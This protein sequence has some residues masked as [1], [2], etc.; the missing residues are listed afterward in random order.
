M[1][2]PLMK[3][4]KYAAIQL[5]HSTICF[6]SSYMYLYT[7]MIF[8]TKNLGTIVAIFCVLQ[9]KVQSL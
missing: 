8:G 6:L 7:K 5:L 2:V 3:P 4:E 9:H 1:I